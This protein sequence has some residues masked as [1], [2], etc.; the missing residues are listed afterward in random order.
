MWAAVSDPLTPMGG[1]GWI[2]P[3][4]H[5]VHSSQHTVGAQYMLVERMKEMTMCSLGFHSGTG[6]IVGDFYFL[7][8]EFP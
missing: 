7:H 3:D 5:R 8:A 2:Y 1:V 6:W 4:H